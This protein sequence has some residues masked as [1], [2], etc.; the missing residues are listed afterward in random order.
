MPYLSLLFSCLRDNNESATLMGSRRG[1]GRR[2]GDAPG[3]AVT[4]FAK[5][6]HQ[7]K[8]ALLSAT[9]SLRCG[10]TCVG[11]LAGCAVELTSLLRSCV[12]T[13]TASEGLLTLCKGIALPRKGAVC[14]AH[15]RSKAGALQARATPQTAPLRG[16]PKG[17][18]PE[19]AP[20]RCVP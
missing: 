5:K 14:K 17:R 20:R 9:P 16:N 15:V 11:A 8:L 19:P 7:K 2:P 3:G 13:A 6:S 10:A 4:F 12:Q 1:K 18:S